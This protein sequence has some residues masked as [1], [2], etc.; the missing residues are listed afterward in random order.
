MLKL[1]GIAISNYYNM[2]KQSLLEKGIRFEEIMAPPSQDP[3]FLAKSPMGKIPCLETPD[4]YLSESMAIIDYLED[5]HPAQPLYAA[6]AFEKAKAKE[7][8]RIA[9]LYLDIPARRHLGH[10]MFGAELS[11]AAVDEVRP[12]IEKGLAALRRIARYEPWIAGSSFGYA[13]IVLLHALRM[14]LLI[15]PAVY[16]WDP[17]AD[18]PELAA[19]MERINAR[20][21]TVAVLEAQKQ[22]L[23]A[24]QAKRNG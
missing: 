1:H 11:Q 18:E 19:W 21:H 12:A 15:M 17:L 6:S 9:E 2:V 24:M 3:A 13:D 7:I 4:G 20:E 8:M 16:Q 23:A 22:T 5:T 14:V 10:V